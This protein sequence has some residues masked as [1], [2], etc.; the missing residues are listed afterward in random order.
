M[1]NSYRLP[2]GRV[3]PT[4]TPDHVRAAVGQAKAAHRTGGELDNQGLRAHLIGRAAAIGAKHLIPASW[5][6]E[7]A[8]K[9][10]ADIDALITEL[11]QFDPT[12]VDGVASAANGFGFLLT[13]AAAISAAA[14]PTPLGVAGVVVKAEPVRRYTLAVAYPANKADVS[15]AADGHQDFAGAQAV[16]D[17]AWSYLVKSPQVGL[18]HEQGTDGAGQ[19][20]ESYVYR[21]PDWEIPG[22]GGADQVVKS[23]DWLLGVVWEPGAWDL[24]KT[25][26]V[27][28]VSVQGSAR[29]RTPS[30]E[31]LAALRKAQAFTERHSATGALLAKAADCERQADLISDRVLSDSYRQ[32][33]RQLREQAAGPA[34]HLAK[35]GRFERLAQQMSDPRDR[36][37]YIELAAKE[38]QKAGAA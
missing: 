25:G 16:E 1:A 20:V 32:Q 4:E 37:A 23:G 22:P 31:A 30:P 17:A 34:G 26:R 38:R 29:R 12:R 35:A 3:I 2:S 7:S 15:I 5:A 21:G 28:G 6:H 14:M 19:V 18:W 27:G 11:E 8:G 36:S 33:A 9:S 13:K 24:I 10:S